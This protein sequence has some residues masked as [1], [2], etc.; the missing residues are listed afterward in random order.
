MSDY[1][2]LVTFED[3]E[4]TDVRVAPRCRLIAAPFTSGVE[5]LVALLATFG[6]QVS[7]FALPEYATSEAG[8]EDHRLRQRVWES[9]LQSKR[10]LLF[11]TREPRAA[12][13]AE[14][15]AKEDIFGLPP[16]ETWAYHTLF[17]L[18][19]LPQTALHVVRAEEIAPGAIGLL[20]TILRGLQVWA[21]EPDIASA[22]EKDAKAMQWNLSPTPD[23]EYGFSP[24][25]IVAMQQLGYAVPDESRP[26]F[27]APTHAHLIAGVDAAGN[28][29]LAD[30]QLALAMGEPAKAEQALRALLAE[31]AAS[32]VNRFVLG[33]SLLALRW[34]R[35]L[36]GD[37][38]VQLPAAQQAFTLFRDWNYQSLSVPAVLRQIMA[39]SGAQDD[40][41][42]YNALGEA[43]YE[44]GTHDAAE[45]VFR[46][47]LALA[48]DSAVVHNNLAA[49]YWERSDID[50]AIAHIDTAYRLD[51]ANPD[52]VGNCT[53]MRAALGLAA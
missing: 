31:G 36:F 15:Q 28:M 48:P 40:A 11:V 35:A 1:F 20:R 5:R 47:A 44:L 9:L 3:I 42:V 7:P 16:A 10:P 6:V 25:V 2:N 51:P 30:A 34:T 50:A 49:I 12:L 52:V 24:V 18:S 41:T 45:A 29:A 53:A 26:A 8:E 22:L 39:E 27:A 21:S 43:L 37:F 13:F 4:W 19:V 32:L 38:A 33:N 17:W 14:C 46:A 23:E